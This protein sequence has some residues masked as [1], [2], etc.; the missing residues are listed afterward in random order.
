MLTAA[1]KKER[2]KVPT[3]IDARIRRDPF[4]AAQCLRNAIIAHR[5]DIIMEMKNGG[6]IEFCDMT[7]SL[8]DTLRCLYDNPPGRQNGIQRV[9][10]AINKGI[11]PINGKQ[12]AR[13]VRNRGDAHLAVALSKYMNHD[14]RVS[15]IAAIGRD[16]KMMSILIT[17]D[18]FCGTL[19]KMKTVIDDK[20]IF[21]AIMDGK[22]WMIRGAAVVATGTAI[23]KYVPDEVLRYTMATVVNGNI[24][25]WR[26]RDLY[27]AIHGSLFRAHGYDDVTII[28][29]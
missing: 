12:F 16:G 22:R 21:T 27:D 14:H 8:I 1:K 2:M 13:L 23:G 3:N 20:S 5:D 4:Y 25:A 18:L 9:L 10:W 7:F 15:I 28:C 19:M 29:E 11:I 6:Y 24:I 26:L 17:D